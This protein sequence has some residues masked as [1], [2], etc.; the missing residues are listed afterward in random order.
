M[1]GTMPTINHAAAK[2]QGTTSV[3]PKMS[4]QDAASAAEAYVF[5]FISNLKFPI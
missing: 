5:A 3:V 2:R 4:P 1:V